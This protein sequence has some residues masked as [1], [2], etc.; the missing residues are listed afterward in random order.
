MS[1]WTTPYIGRTD[2]HCWALVRAIFAEQ[3][4]IQLPEYGDIDAG[5]LDAVARAVQEGR[6]YSATWYRVDPFPGGEEPFDIVVMKGWLPGLDG[7]V[8]RGVIHTGVV[9]RKG[10]VIHTDVGYAV[11]EV[12]LSHPML[13]RRV[14]GCYRHV[15]H[16]GGGGGASVTAG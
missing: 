14:V 13:R 2:M 8:R 9:T 11:V 10:H 1:G 3:R 16:G 15:S 7:V 6:S 4:G 5:E 12:S